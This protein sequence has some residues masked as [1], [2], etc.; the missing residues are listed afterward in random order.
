MV[1]ISDCFYLKPDIYVH[2]ES[3]KTMLSTLLGKFSNRTIVCFPIKSWMFTNRSQISLNIVP[4]VG[5]EMPRENVLFIHMSEFTG[6][7]GMIRS[8]ALPASCSEEPY[9]LHF[10]IN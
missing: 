8:R 6:A 4:A 10:P 3:S 5:L 7:W 9:K 2:L 1:Q